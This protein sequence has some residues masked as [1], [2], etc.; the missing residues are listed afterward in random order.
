MNGSE[1]KLQL[2]PAIS[3]DNI[4]LDNR[5]RMRVVLDAPFF[6]EHTAPLGFLAQDQ[7]CQ[8]LFHY[9]LIA[10]TNLE[11]QAD[12]LVYEGERDP[13]YDYR[14]LF[15]SISVIHATTPEAMSKWWS[16]VDMECRMRQLPLIPDEERYRFN[17]VIEIQT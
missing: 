2:I 10:R 16:N 14:S 9:Y 12:P 1:S 13:E 4:S 3:H 17:R 8:A 5:R 6:K 11:K 7:S 15:K